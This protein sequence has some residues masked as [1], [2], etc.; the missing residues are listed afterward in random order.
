MAAGTVHHRRTALIDVCE[1]EETAAD[2]PTRCLRP[3]WKAVL[4]VGVLVE[5]ERSRLWVGFQDRGLEEADIIGTEYLFGDLLEEGM[6]DQVDERGGV[7]VAGRAVAV[8]RLIA[9]WRLLE[10]EQFVD[11]GVGGGDFIGCQCCVDGDSA[12]LVKGLQCFETYHRLLPRTQTSRKKPW[13]LSLRPPMTVEFMQ[14]L[15]SWWRTVTW[16]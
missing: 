15:G 2:D 1:P 12:T 16:L 5:A 13:R 4:N 11:G 8:A 6:L 9:G 7:E 14:G 3:V 10:G